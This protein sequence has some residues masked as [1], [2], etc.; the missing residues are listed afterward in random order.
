MCLLFYGE[1][2]TDFFGEPNNKQLMILQVRR[3]Y[4][5]W[6]RKIKSSLRKDCKCQV[7]IAEKA[8]SEQSWK[9]SEY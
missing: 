1:N 9:Q 2:H 7:G 6:K 3:C 5:L 8:S 4:V